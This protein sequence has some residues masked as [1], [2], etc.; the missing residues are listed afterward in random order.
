[1][2]FKPEQVQMVLLPQ[3]GS[4]H[5]QITP[6]PY[7]GIARVFISSYIKHQKYIIA[8]KQT[9]STQQ[10]I[11]LRVNNTKIIALSI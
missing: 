1:M 3:H 8:H 5:H 2:K 7:N 6:A 4:H 9:S 11:F 10:V